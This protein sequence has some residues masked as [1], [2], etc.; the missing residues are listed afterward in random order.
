MIQLLQLPFRV[1]CVYDYLMFY[2]YRMLHFNTSLERAHEFV[3]INYSQTG[4]IRE[5][6][7][8]LPGNK[9]YTDNSAVFTG[10]RCY[11]FSERDPIEAEDVSNG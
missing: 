8:R 2:Y 4:E 11:R 9:Q 3:D 6:A 10:V 5:T 7:S 1:A